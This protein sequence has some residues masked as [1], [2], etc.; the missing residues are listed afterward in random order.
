MIGAKAIE[1]SELWF[2]TYDHH[3]AASSRSAAS[4][5]VGLLGLAWPAT[6]TQTS[7]FSGKIDRDCLVPYN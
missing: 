6:A 5:R 3:D 2:L 7:L 1:M 4:A